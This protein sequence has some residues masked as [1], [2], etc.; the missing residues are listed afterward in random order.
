MKSKMLLDFL[1]LSFIIPNFT[2][3]WHGGMFKCDT[4]LLEMECTFGNGK[5]L[6]CA[7]T[8]KSHMT[9]ERDLSNL[10]CHHFSLKSVGNR[11]QAGLNMEIPII[12]SQNVAFLRSLVF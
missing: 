4:F 2:F 1:F 12:L 5:V 9:L 8:H 6:L 11:H 3:S 10:L 7:F